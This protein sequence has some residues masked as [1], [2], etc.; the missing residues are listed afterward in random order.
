M[1]KTVLLTAII[2]SFLALQTAIAQN[3]VTTLQH[4]GTTQ[5]FY[6]QNSF[7]D[8]YNASI[9]GDTIYLSTGYFT[10]PS[11]IA[12]G[13]K[14]IGAGHFPDSA[15]VAKRTYILSKINIAQGADS[16]L[17]EGLYINGDI[18]YDANSSINYVKVLRCGLYSANFNSN[19]A[20]A[21]KNNCSYEECFINGYFA[22]DNYGDNLLI[23][24]CIISACTTNINEDALIDGNIFLMIGLEIYNTHP[25][26]NINS[27]LIKN[28]IILSTY[29]PIYNCNGNYF[30]NNL[31]VQSSV[32]FENNSYSNNYLGIPQANIF[33]SQSGNEIDYTHDYHLQHPE[34]YIGTDGTQVG[35]YGG[36]IP[37][38][39]KGNPSNPQVI[40]KNI[41]T[42]TDVNGNLPISITVE[43]QDN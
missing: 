7:V 2:C 40:S 28:N 36:S 20:A 22:F 33:V 16:L 31:F 13:V 5:A 19:S 29:V 24:H 39:D 4:N 9:N 27:S 8:A 30:Y 15:G 32:N 41:A 6:G 37:F 14:I 18:I 21:G 11:S 43:A 10:P 35:L 25:L 42:E 1:K 3:P 34:L 23:R 38:K 17:L 26:G 12:K